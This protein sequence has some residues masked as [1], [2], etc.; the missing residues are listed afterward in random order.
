MNNVTAPT[1]AFPYPSLAIKAAKIVA[2]T[3]SLI[4]AGLRYRLGAKIDPLDLQAPELVANHIGEVDCS[5]FVRWVI[6]HATGQPANFDFP[7]GSVQ[8]HEWIEAK[9]FKLSTYEDAHND[10]GIVRIAFLT[11][12]DG[13]GVGHVLLIVNGQT[14]ESHGSHGPDHR[15][16]GSEGWMQKMA[17]YVLSA[18]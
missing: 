18:P 11:P 6:Y 12:E 9:G 8:Q 5:G 16:W 14:C 4:T 1:E 7:D 17:V 3:D 13:G 10:D 15:V 2:L